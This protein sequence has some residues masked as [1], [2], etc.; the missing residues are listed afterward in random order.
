MTLDVKKV[1]LLKPLNDK[2]L[3]YNILLARPQMTKKTKFVQCL[4]PTVRVVRRGGVICVPLPF[5]A[6]E[7]LWNNCISQLKLGFSGLKLSVLGLVY[8]FKA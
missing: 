6:S 5:V 1:M 8:P 2:S 7:R 4:W 3:W